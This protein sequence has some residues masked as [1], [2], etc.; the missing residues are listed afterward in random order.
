M[1][2]RRDSRP[3]SSKGLTG[4]DKCAFKMAT[5]VALGGKPP[6]LPTC[7]RLLRWLLASSKSDKFKRKGKDKDTVSCVTKSLKSHIIKS[8][9]FLFARS[10]SSPDTLKG[11]EVEIMFLLLKGG[12]WKNLWTYFKAATFPTVKMKEI[13]LGVPL[14]ISS[15]CACLCW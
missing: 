15:V 4:V 1:M 11:I 3:C 7:S 9:F 13:T 12:V 8:T 10:K 6:F 14:N 5:H 2:P